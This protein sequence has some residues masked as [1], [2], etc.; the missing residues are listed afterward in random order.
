VTTFVSRAAGKLT[1]FS[2]PLTVGKPKLGSSASVFGPDSCGRPHP[3]EF[4]CTYA[5]GDVAGSGKLMPKT[6]A[7]KR[8]ELP[9]G[10][11]A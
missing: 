2:P 10:N 5:Y 9:A 11:A 3:E 7:F 6:V 1:A 4:I 8:G